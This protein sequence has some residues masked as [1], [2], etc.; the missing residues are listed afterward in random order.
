MNALGGGGTLAGKEPEMF[1]FLVR[2]V[3]GWVHFRG[4]DIV[5]GVGG[6]CEKMGWLLGSGCQLVGARL[7]EL[8]ILHVLYSRRGGEEKRGEARG[9][10]G[11]DG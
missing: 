11:H 7:W 9:G 4:C 6:E 1:Y 5:R 10:G 3:D 8:E 2:C